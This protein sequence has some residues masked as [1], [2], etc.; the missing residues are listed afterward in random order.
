MSNALRILLLAVLS[1]LAIGCGPEPINLTFVN[2]VQDSTVMLTFQDQNQEVRF[3]HAFDSPK[4]SRMPVEVPAELA[5][6]KGTLKVS[7]RSNLG[8]IQDLN[9]LDH[10]WQ[11]EGEY[12]IEYLDEGAIYSDWR[13]AAAE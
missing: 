12:L 1:T 4:G 11:L 13:V 5:G 2:E 7:I 10:S 6:I 8:G 3:V 9:I